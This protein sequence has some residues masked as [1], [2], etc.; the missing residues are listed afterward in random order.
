MTIHVTPIPSTI[1]LVAP[2]F[3]LGGANAAGSSPSAVAANSTI[4]SVFNANVDL[5]SNLLVG[6]AG[7]TGI[8]IS[9]NGEVTM[10]AQPAFAAFKTTASTNQTGNGAAVTLGFDS[11]I[12]D[13]NGDYDGVNTFTAP[14]TGK[15]SFTTKLRLYNQT[16][17]S[18]YAL[19]Q[20]VTSNRTWYFYWAWWQTTGSSGGPN[21]VA[22]VDMDASDTATVVVTSYGESSD[23]VTIAGDS[24][25]VTW[26][27]GIKVA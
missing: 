25:P 14:V 18:T 26:W 8:A 22:T 4:S 15:Y 9:A 17:S 27:T 11:E 2:S 19:M 12:F 13:V 10:A 23:L 20:V 5:G 1:E 3:T 21:L 24:Y 16:A 6:N 7:T